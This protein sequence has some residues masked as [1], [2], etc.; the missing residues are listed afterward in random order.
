MVKDKRR[1][2]EAI[3]RFDEI[4][5]QDPRHEFSNGRSY[6]K[7]LLYAQRMTE[8]LLS[9]SPDAAEEVQLAA[10]CQHI[11]RWHIPRDSYPKDRKGYKSWRRDLLEFHAGIA[12]GI[13]AEA[14][15]DDEMVSRVKALLIKEDLKRNPNVQLLEDVICLVFLEHYFQDFSAEHSEEKLLGIL[16]KTWRKMSPAGHSAA[17]ALDL[18]PNTKE[19]IQKALL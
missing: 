3:R 6:P 16:Q 13:L 2:D 9:F 7:E 11:K 12:S 18:P 1:F 17:L 5:A 19:I 10:R 15:Y 8:K 14:G 4:N